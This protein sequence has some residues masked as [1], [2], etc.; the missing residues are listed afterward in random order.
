MSRENVE[1]VRALFSAFDRGDRKPVLELYDPE[2]E[3]DATDP[4]V[5]PDMAGV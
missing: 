4:A 1:I 3:W 5:A 2:I